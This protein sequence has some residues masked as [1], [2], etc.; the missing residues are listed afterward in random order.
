MENSQGA[1]TAVP[2]WAARST[3]SDEIVPG[4]VLHLCQPASTALHLEQGHLAFLMKP[5]TGLALNGTEPT[6]A[7][8]LGKELWAS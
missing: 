4:V 7:L 5:G 6:L 2:Y 8:R 3:F 1:E